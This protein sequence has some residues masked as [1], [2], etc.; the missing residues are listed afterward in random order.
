MDIT[1]DQVSLAL[2]EINDAGFC[3]QKFG[4]K[5]HVPQDLAKRIRAMAT[6]LCNLA[7][8]MEEHFDEHGDRSVVE[9]DDNAGFNE[10]M[11]MDIRELLRMRFR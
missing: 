2:E 8:D 5:S 4:E 7:G 9:E 11:D 3:L 10:L 1:Q 6:E